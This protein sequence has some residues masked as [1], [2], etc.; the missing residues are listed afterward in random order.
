MPVWREAFE[1][2]NEVYDLTEKFPRGEQYALTDQVK[3]A[4]TSV[5]ANIAES[6]GRYHVLDKINFYYHA[7]GSLCETKSHLM[8]A[9]NRQYITNDDYEIVQCRIG[10]IFNALNVIIK[11]LRLKYKK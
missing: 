8:F 10:R 7:R 6:F 11:S 9:L 1:L 2:A 3:R 5:S 4:A